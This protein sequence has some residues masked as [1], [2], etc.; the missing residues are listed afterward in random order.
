[1]NQRPQTQFQQHFLGK[2]GAKLPGKL[3]LWFG[4]P[5]KKQLASH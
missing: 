4:Q 5:L 2:K 3:F 1:M